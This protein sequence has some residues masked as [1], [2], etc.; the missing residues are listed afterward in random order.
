MTNAIVPLF[1]IEDRSPNVNDIAS[2]GQIWFNRQGSIWLAKTN[3]SIE[4]DAPPF[5]WEQVAGEKGDKGDPGTAGADGATYIYELEEFQDA[6]VNKAVFQV[7]GIVEQNPTDAQRANI[8][9]YVGAT[10]F[11]DDRA[12]AVNVRG[13]DGTGSGT[14]LSAENLRKLAD[15]TETTQQETE[16]ITDFIAGVINI[17]AGESFD[18]LTASQNNIVSVNGSGTIVIGLTT[19]DINNVEATIDTTTYPIAPSKWNEVLI[20]GVHQ[21]HNGY[22]LYFEG[23]DEN[24][25]EVR[26]FGNDN[27]NLLLNYNRNTYIY[28]FQNQALLDESSIPTI[29]ESKLSLAVRT[30]LN[31]VLNELTQEQI[32]KLA[33]LIATYST[34][35]SDDISYL[36]K[37][38]RA[39]ST[40]SDYRGGKIPPQTNQTL[41]TILVSEADATEASQLT[42]LQGN[43]SL[44]SANISISGYLAYTANIPGIGS[45]AEPTEFSLSGTIRNL[46]SLTFSDLTKIGVSNL[47]QAVLDLI[48]NE[49]ASLPSILQYLASHI[50][51]NDVVHQSI[52]TGTGIANL[53]TALDLNKAVALLFDKPEDEDHEAV[54]EIIGD[55]N[56]SESIPLSKACLDLS[57]SSAKRNNIKLSLFLYFNL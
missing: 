30:K 45:T 5:I 20:N 51:F 53:A 6:G 3:D 11:V 52:A 50:S 42:S 10:G 41:I 29:E 28:K 21:Q 26:N 38:G 55:S 17:D 48:N 13:I 54:N 37:I 43:A 46:S 34:E 22:Y 31:R 14:M 9:K 18:D 1:I 40:F 19:Q 15:I 25:H 44:T 24:T 23:A 32:K 57:S 39:T 12:D 35:S 27:V 36:W 56:N 4:Q 8:N 2:D 49:D 33:Q 16:A 47:S 7:A